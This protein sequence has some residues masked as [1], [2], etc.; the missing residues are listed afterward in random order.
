MS[1]EAD[2]L[3]D[4]LRKTDYTPLECKSG[5]EMFKVVANACS[6]LQPRSIVL[7]RRNMDL[8]IEHYEKGD[9]P[10]LKRQ[11]LPGDIASFRGV[12][13]VCVEPPDRA[14]ADP[15]AELS[16][17]AAILPKLQL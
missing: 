14:S 13:I 16:V 11:Y 7:S 1:D 4:A 15:A 5:E 17:D 3:A 2:S 9:A 6:G 12:P 10:G 8:L